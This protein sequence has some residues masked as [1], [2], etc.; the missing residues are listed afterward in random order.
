MGNVMTIKFRK[1]NFYCREILLSWRR[2]LQVIAIAI[3]DSNRESQITGDLRQC[4][5]SEQNL[6]VVTYCTANGRC[7]ASGDWT[8]APN[9]RLCGSDLQFEPH[10]K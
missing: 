10:L 4:E 9:H 5:P 1:L 2:L 3:C 6:I 7:Y 8:R